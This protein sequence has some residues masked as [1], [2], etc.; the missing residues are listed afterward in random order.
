MDLNI[1]EKRAYEPRKTTSKDLLPYDA[2][3]HIFEKNL[4]DMLE[5]KIISN[6]AEDD[7]QF[8][9]MLKD[10]NF[11]EVFW[12]LPEEIEQNAKTAAKVV[13]NLFPLEVNAAYM[14]KINK[15][16]AKTANPQTDQSASTSG[17]SA[18]DNRLQ[19]VSLE[20]PTE[21]FEQLLKKNVLTLTNNTLRDA[22]FNEY[23]TYLRAAIWH[24]LFDAASKNAL[25][26]DKIV[27][28]LKIYRKSCY[29][30][31]TLEQYNKWIAALKN[32][33]Q[34]ENMQHFWNEHIEPCE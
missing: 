30:F 12:K 15:P 27:E 18:A 9:E 7:E 3:P 19:K 32:N 11:V 10:K 16:A 13:K 23:A 31:N 2:F 17:N 25:E 34:A 24:L 21:D 1:P 28:A 8:Q 5:R 14:N 6:S 29:D 26:T 33:I 20:T 22:K 4:M